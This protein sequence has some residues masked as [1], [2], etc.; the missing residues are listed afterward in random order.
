[1]NRHDKKVV[2]RMKKDVEEAMGE[3]TDEEIGEVFAEIDKY[4]IPQK[5]RD[6]K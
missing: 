6:N 1:M 3:L 5:E 4:F 2:E